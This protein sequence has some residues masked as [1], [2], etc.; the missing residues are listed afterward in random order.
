MEDGG[1][2]NLELLYRGSQ[3]RWKASDFNVKCDNKGSTIT[4]IRSTGGFIFGGFADKAWKSSVGYCKS[5]KAF[6]FSLKIP[7]NEVR[8]T[9]THIKQNMC[10]KAI[11][12]ISSH[13]PSFGGCNDLYINSDTNNN[14]NSNSYLGHTYELPPGQTN[15]F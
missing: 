1:S 6:F 9:K 11:Y 4:A 13:G 15:T 5:D 8:P 12:H 10:S 7:S 2:R 14:R 3:V